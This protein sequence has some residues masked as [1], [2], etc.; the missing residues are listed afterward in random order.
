L[1]E[2]NFLRKI[3]AAEDIQEQRIRLFSLQRKSACSLQ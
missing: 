1:D 3:T 2:V